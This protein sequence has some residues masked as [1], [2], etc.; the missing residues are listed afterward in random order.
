MET[1]PLLKAAGATRLVSGSAVFGAED[2][3]MAI[4]QLINS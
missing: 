3:G 4:E 1:A 2:M